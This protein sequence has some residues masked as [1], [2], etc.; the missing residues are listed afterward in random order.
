MW[1]GW[2]KGTGPSQLPQAPK[3]GRDLVMADRAR[4]DLTFP[5][6]IN[7]SKSTS[8]SMSLNKRSLARC[9]SAALVWHMAVTLLAKNWT[10]LLHWLSSSICRTV[11]C[12]VEMVVLLFGGWELTGS[13]EP[14]SD[15]S[16]IKTLSRV[17]LVKT[18]ND[19]EL[20]GWYSVLHTLGN[21]PSAQ[22]GGAW[23]MAYQIQNVVIAAL[24]RQTL[25]SRLAPVEWQITHFNYLHLY[26]ILINRS[27]RSRC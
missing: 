4:L 10:V 7:W 9:V 13:S 8:G 16:T 19:C 22:A 5:S 17:C 3:G 14:Q 6:G 26:W 21:N 2:W 1:S 18:R 24:S 11:F 15:L 27:V 25:C 12:S 23:K 20:E